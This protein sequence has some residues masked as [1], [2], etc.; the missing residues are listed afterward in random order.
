[1]TEALRH[2]PATPPIHRLEDVVEDLRAHGHPVLAGVDPRQADLELTGIALSSG[3]CQP[4]DLFVALPGARGHG[5]AYVTQALEAGAVAVLTD[6]AGGVVVHEFTTRRGR[7]APPMLII[8]EPRAVLGALT[9]WWYDRPAE[10]FTLIGITGTQGKTTTTYLAEAAIGPRAA[11]IGTIGTRIGGRPV[12]STLTTPEAPALQAL[13]AVMVEESVDVC[14]MEVSSHALIQGRVDGVQFDTAVFLNLGRDHLDFHAD[15]Q[16]YFE[17]KA[18][19]FTPRRCRRAVVNIDDAWGRTLVERLEVP[20]VTYS[21]QGDPAADWRVEPIGAD[22]T[23]TDVVVVGPDA[24]RAPLRVPLPGE[25]NV[26][27][28]LA[29]CAALAEPT[30]PLADVTAKLATCA[31]VPGRLERIEAGQDFTAVVDYA[32]KPEAVTAVLGALRPITAGRLIVVIG[33]G[34]DRDTGKRPLMGEAAARGADLVIITDDNPRSE[35]PAQIRAAVL[36]GVP[37]GSAAE[38]IECGDRRAAIARA[39]AEAAPGDTVVIAG[40]GH[41]SGQD[42][43]GVVQPFDDRIELR[44]AI[45][46]RGVSR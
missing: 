24:Q 26:S 28:A 1:M 21:S 17:A 3:D 5:A 11:V 40:K 34:G 9:S 39:V 44:V 6:A 10:Q 20:F 37:A 4:G 22:A 8:A 45:E 12:A 38:V 2:R 46:A 29:V 13:F 41:E 16:D 43:A 15:L 31:G 36:T 42:T 23:G 25:F 32:H 35:D 30:R 27:N 19:L 33:A 14:A 7:T 18:Q